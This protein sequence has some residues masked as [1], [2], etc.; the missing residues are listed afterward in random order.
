MSCKIVKAAPAGVLTVILAMAFSGCPKDIDD[1][2]TDDEPS[3]IAFKWKA[4]GTA[5]GSQAAFE[6][7]AVIIGPINN[8]VSSVIITLNNT[9][10]QSLSKGGADAG[11]VTI[12]GSDGTANRTLTVNTSGIAGS[13]G[14]K[15]FTLTVT[16][17]SEY[18]YEVSVVVDDT[19][20]TYRTFWAQK[21]Y[22]KTGSPWYQITAVKAGESAHCIV[23]GDIDLKADYPDTG[24]YT[25][26]QAQELAD[27]YDANVYN[28]I[29]DAFGDIEDMDGN[30]KV[31]FLLLDIVDGYPDKTGGAYVAGYFDSTHMYDTGTYSRSNKTDMLFLDVYPGN[32]TSCRSTMAHE[33]QHLINFSGTVSKGRSQKDTWIDEGLSTGAE[34]I[35]GNA[36]GGDG[37][38]VGR[39]DIYKSYLNSGSMDDRID[40]FFRWDGSLMDYSTDYLFFQW[41]RI[42]SGGTGIYREIIANYNNGD[43][44]DVTA[45][46]SA[47]ISTQFS[48]WD[49]LLSTWFV[50]NFVQQTSG[51]YGYMKEHFLNTGTFSGSSINLYPGEGAFSR[52]TGTK[53]LTDS[54]NIKYLAFNADTGT[55]DED[56]NYDGS[57][58]PYVLTYNVNTDTEGA[59]AAGQL[60]GSVEGGGGLSRAGQPLFSVIG[61]EIP[62]PALPATYPTGFDDVRRL[63][64]L[65]TAAESAK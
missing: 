59:R 25:V 7:G 42:H 24:K 36:A 48:N 33:L 35:Y 65:E 64:G 15:Y 39:I 12:S 44:R 37:D 22:Y 8:G 20:A 58:T 55:V 62:A 43:Y 51:Y 63:H 29:K 11:D 13:G 10:S 4:E 52:L 54:G 16:G 31:I 47:L 23:Y 18:K 2:V 30:G 56:G 41:L 53:N 1:P 60:A 9:A 6:P 3:A 19:E 49:K 17:K 14:M 40:S 46:A 57:A 61:K 34:Y 38:P 45:A 5:G 28:Q 27:E 21:A 50:A 32:T 26:S